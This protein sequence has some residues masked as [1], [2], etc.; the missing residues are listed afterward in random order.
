MACKVPRCAA[1]SCTNDIPSCWL[2][3]P[4][5]SD[6]ANYGRQ[7]EYAVRHPQIRKTM[8]IRSSI[9]AGSIPAL[10][11][12]SVLPNQSSAKPLSSMATL[13]RSMD[14]AFDCG[15][16]TCRNPPGFVE[17]PIAICTD[18][19]PML[20]TS[21]RAS[22]QLRLLAARRLIGIAMCI[23]AQCSVG[24]VDMAGVAGPV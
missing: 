8:N 10:C 6:E 16:T 19:E 11:C 22:P 20:P 7:I 4:V 9:I 23:V 17:T 21:W 2:R 14:I 12:P 18:A 24:A 15:E 1:N 13:S 5:P 3:S